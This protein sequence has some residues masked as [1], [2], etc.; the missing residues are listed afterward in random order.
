M[1]FPNGYTKTS[2]LA[3]SHINMQLIILSAEK[4]LKVK[5]IRMHLAW[6]GSE[7]N[8]ISKLENTLRICYNPILQ[9]LLKQWCYTNSITCIVPST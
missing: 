1:V 5:L 9:D 8:N 3:T 6:K 2:D 4:T 7:K